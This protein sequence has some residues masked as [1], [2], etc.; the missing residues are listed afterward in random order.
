MS[1]GLLI[2]FAVVLVGCA[3]P[4][5]PGDGGGGGS[6][7]AG[8]SGGGGGA[9]GSGGT[10]GS[11][12]GGGAG[13]AGGSG[14]GGSAPDG[15]PIVL[16]KLYTEHLGKLTGTPKSPLVPYGITGTDLG[17]AFERDGKVAF[18]F[19]D[20]WTLA[21]P[22]WDDDSLA[23]ADPQFPTDGGLPALSWAA[24][25]NGHFLPFKLTGVNLEAM[26]V[27]LDAVPDGPKTWVFF[28][29]GFSAA[30]GRHTTSVL[31]H[32]TGLDPRTLALDHAVPSDKFLNIAAV[33][34]GSTVY[35]FGSGPYRTSAVYLARVS[36]AQLSDRA[37][38]QYYRGA[39]ALGP[40]FGPQES[41]AVP[42]VSAACVGEL[43]VRKHP[44][45]GLWMMA[46]NCDTPR[47]ITLR[48]AVAPWGPFSSGL[49]IFD[50]GPDRGYQHFMHAK[51]SV[52][53]HDDGLGEPGREEEWGGEYGPYL[54]PAWFSQGPQGIHFITWVLS[55]WNPY[56]AHLMR[57]ALAEDGATHSRPPRG[58]GLP[59]AALVN[60]DF[61]AGL[62]GWQ[63]AGDPFV[64]FTG[65]DGKPRVSTFVQPAGDATQGRLWQDFTVD[66]TTSV[67]KFTIHGGDAE[68]QLWRGNEL[69]RST[70][71]RR[72]NT[73]ET[74]VEWRLEEF[75]GATV[76]LQIED[77]LGG[78]WGF[79]GCS[80]FTL[81]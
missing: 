40:V 29:T 17:V 66:S 43:S 22:D 37:Q 1:R 33:L 62:T 67:L 36:L 48:T 46:Y 57:T 56:Q 24:D 9:G 10:G 11:G 54:V 13:G 70:R 23:W 7:G 16:R 32:M 71:G 45:L 38:W 79:V 14:G 52:V 3:L 55:S 31:A 73:P 65:G 44:G 69:V 78:A 39:D 25:V 6:G 28:N 15:G 35:L 76:R 59:K 12:A 60:G 47:G 50:P 27:P 20:S 30:T 19:G 64:T 77:A 42:L 58:V 53:G 5:D 61:A 72:A 81:Q 34:E 21:L 2:V 80:G 26:N 41:S 63:S 51:P 49:N 18:L 74:N 75:Q 8:G 4:A 68:V